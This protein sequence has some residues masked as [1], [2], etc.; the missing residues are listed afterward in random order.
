VNHQEENE[1]LAS[2]NILPSPPSPKATLP[3]FP[4]P[5]RP[6]AP[7]KYDLALLG[8]D[9][10]LTDAEIVD[11]GITMPIRVDS[12]KC[13]SG[14]DEKTRRRLSGLGITQLFAGQ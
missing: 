2:N 14:L 13:D 10:A 1:T 6:N 7:S 3:S 11:S 8:V 4:L 9:K 5:T 12:D